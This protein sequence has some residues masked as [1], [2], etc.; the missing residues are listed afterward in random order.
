M[1]RRSL[2]ILGSTGSIGQSTI[3]VVR[4]NP[5][6]FDVHAL[7]AYRNVELLENQYHEFRPEYIGLVDAEAAKILAGKLS[8]EPVEVVSGSDEIVKLAGLSGV[9]IVLNAIVGAAG[10]KASVETIRTGKKLA[11][12]NKESLV[13]GGPLFAKVCLQDDPQI[14]PVDSEHSAIWQALRAGQRQEVRN[15][16]LTASGGPFRTLPID[17]FE[18]ITVEQ[19][20][21]HP[22]WKMGRKITIDSATLINKGLEVLEAVIL[23][24]VEPSQVKVVI[25]P[26]SIVHSMVEYVDSSVVAQLSEPD[27]CLPIACALFWPERIK[28]NYGR[29]DWTE[30][31]NLSFEPPDLKRFPALQLAFEVAAE[32]GTAPAIYNAANEIA[33]EA[34]LGGAV[35]FTEIVDITRKTLNEIEFIDQ[36]D[37]EDI[38]K[39]D[40][41]ARELAGRIR[42]KMAC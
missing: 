19:A 21:N 39:A 16:I 6:C 23:F 3:K 40:S 12:A 15:L 30:I 36:P 25:H 38:L 33:V 34:F 18:N 10:L 5:G 20:L 31:R 41:R 24:G 1:K 8:H 37:L 14:L 26:Q 27:M 11:L 2:A 32:G 4:D 35:K 28:Q 9:D 17:Q 7:A 22:T 29:M 42:E 13:A